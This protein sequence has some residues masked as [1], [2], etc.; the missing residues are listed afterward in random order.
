MIVFGDYQIFI[1]LLLL[2]FNLEKCDLFCQFSLWIYLELIRLAPP[3]IY[4]SYGL[5]L[6]VE[7]QHKWDALVE[8]LKPSISSLPSRV[9]Q[10]VSERRVTALTRVVVWDIVADCWIIKL[11][12]DLIYNLVI[13]DHLLPL[14]GASVQE[15]VELLISMRCLI[16]RQRVII[17][18]CCKYTRDLHNSRQQMCRQE[19]S[20]ELSCRFRCHPIDY[21]IQ[22]DVFNVILLLT[23]HGLVKPSWLRHI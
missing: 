23:S 15:E 2:V 13:L 18:D 3:L 4:H 10:N 16:I 14:F 12:Q 11:L 7:S 20:T 6:R 19:P 21:S 1:F 17:F 5:E 8:V 9:I 22:N